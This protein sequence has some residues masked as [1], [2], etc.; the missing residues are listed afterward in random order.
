MVMLLVWFSVMW[1]VWKVVGQG[2]Y[3]SWFYWWSCFSGVRWMFDWEGDF[4]L[5]VLVVMLVW[6]LLLTD[7]FLMNYWY[8]ITLL[9]L[10]V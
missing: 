2:C 6:L 8:G 3:S 9:L 1:I 10:L 7:S 4:M 5:E